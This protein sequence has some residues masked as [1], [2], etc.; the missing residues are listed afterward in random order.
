MRRSRGRA[1]RYRCFLASPISRRI[2]NSPDVSRGFQR[3]PKQKS[4]P[5]S[6]NRQ[7][8]RHAGRDLAATRQSIEEN[9]RSGLERLRQL[10]PAALRIDDERMRLLGKQRSRRECRQAHRDLYPHTRHAARL[11]G[12]CWGVSHGSH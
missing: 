12:L 1:S 9:P 6:S 5:V 10:Y 7:A 8:V 11:A 4:F 3:Q 2:L